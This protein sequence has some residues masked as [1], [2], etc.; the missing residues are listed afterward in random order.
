[1]L[2][3]AQVA[4]IEVT[5]P[6]KDVRRDVAILE[7]EN[8][9]PPG[10]YMVIEHI[11]SGNRPEVLQ[12]IPSQRIEG[13]LLF[14]ADIPA[15]SKGV[16][17]IHP[18]TTQ[19]AQEYPQRVYAQ[20][21][22]RDQKLRYPRI[23]SVEF[24]GSE[25]PRYTYDAIYGHG[26]MWESD[27]VGFRV[28]MDHRQS[29]D[30]YGKKH[31]RMELDTVNFYSNRDLLKA[32]YGEDILW[33]GQSVGAGSF[34]GLREGKPVYVDSVAARGQRVVEAGPLRTVVEVWDKDW[35][36]NGKTLQ[37]KQVYTM[38]GGHRDVQVDIY[39]EGA[40]DKDLFATGAQKLEM[41]NEGLLLKKEGL[42]GSWGRNVPEKGA[43]DLIEG[44]G[45][46]VYAEPQY[47]ARVQEDDLNYLIYLHPV[48]GHI[49]YHLNVC[50]D[51]QLEGGYHNAKDWF[52]YLK[53]WREEL[54][55][56]LRKMTHFN[57]KG[58]KK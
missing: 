36:I 44:V 4:T 1:M 39:L 54:R 43:P 53:S 22:L 29:I 41:E 13:G 6:G 24:L 55:H 27:Y 56:P 11:I 28:Y 10:D 37:M 21:K 49:R 52:E 12:E 17:T 48:D 33:A 34:R 35:K 58:S 40:S 9:L 30:L 5:N 14:L 3:S 15:K 26:A 32:G 7:T 38:Y 47:V 46:G 51:M 45:I 31:P 16:Y 8:N 18:R 57:S 20:L 50:A 42:V 19:S 25:D 2:A 23:N